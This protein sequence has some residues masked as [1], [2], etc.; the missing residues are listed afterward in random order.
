[1]RAQIIG[2]LIGFAVIELA[3]GI[4]WFFGVNRMLVMVALIGL[5]I[6]AIIVALPT[7]ML[8]RSNRLSIQNRPPSNSN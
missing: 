1:M 7:A 5:S 6:L 8:I 3:I 2:R 4:S